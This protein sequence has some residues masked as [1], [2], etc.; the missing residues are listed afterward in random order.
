MPQYAKWRTTDTIFRELNFQGSDT[1]E[2][3]GQRF[4]PLEKQ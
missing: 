3:Y 4:D 2:S 1:L